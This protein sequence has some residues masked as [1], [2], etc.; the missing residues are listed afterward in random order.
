M[1]YTIRKVI[2]G[3]VYVLYHWKGRNNESFMFYTIRKAIIV[4]VYHYIPLERA[5]QRVLN[6]FYHWKR[7]HIGFLGI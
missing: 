6:V 3:V 1:F 2:R 5:P 7:E 4:S